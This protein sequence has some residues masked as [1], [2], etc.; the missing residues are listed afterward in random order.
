MLE[1]QEQEFH[2]VVLAPQLFLCCI[3]MNAQLIIPVT[4]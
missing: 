4:S 2:K 3:Q 1:E